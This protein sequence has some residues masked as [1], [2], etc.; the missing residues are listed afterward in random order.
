MAEC[1]LRIVEK[2]TGTP[3]NQKTEWVPDCIGDGCS[4]IYEHR[5]AAARA[6]VQPKCTPVTVGKFVRG[7]FQL[8]EPDDGP[9]CVCVIGECEATP[10]K[11]AD[12]ET[13]TK[14]DCAA[15][16]GKT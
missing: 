3:P 2:K 11:G 12:G 1:E 14:I 6:K 10:T 5:G 7:K 8:K 13:V 15:R 9:K 16:C 4:A